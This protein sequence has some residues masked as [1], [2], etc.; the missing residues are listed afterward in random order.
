MFTK[1]SLVISVFALISPHVVSPSKMFS[2]RSSR[3]Q[4][5]IEIR[6]VL[7]EVG[8]SFVCYVRQKIFNYQYI[9]DLRHGWKYINYI[10]IDIL[11]LR[12]EYF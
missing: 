2:N 5:K 7:T 1:E 4:K 3:Y 6:L 9:R 8:K 11:E 12:H 10:A